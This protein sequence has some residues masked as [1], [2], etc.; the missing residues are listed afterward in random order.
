M[1][2]ESPITENNAN[3][4]MEPSEPTL[5]LKDEFSRRVELLVSRVEALQASRLDSFSERS[6]RRSQ[7]AG[8]VNERSPRSSRLQTADLHDIPE[9]RPRSATLS[10]VEEGYSSEEPRLPPK[11][12]PKASRSVSMSSVTKRKKKNHFFDC[13]CN[14]LHCLE[15]CVASHDASSPREVE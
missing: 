5:D 10:S 2:V 7:T 11:A 13:I 12:S 8:F 4:G 6:P 9:Q 14:I 1:I 3:F 15:A